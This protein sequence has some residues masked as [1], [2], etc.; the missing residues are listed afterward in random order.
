MVE[1]GGLWLL[2]LEESGKIYFYHRRLVP[3]DIISMV[4][5]LNG[6]FFVGD[7]KMVSTYNAIIV[8]R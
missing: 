1:F 2:Y 5:R 4:A 8:V 3:S 7:N 6:T